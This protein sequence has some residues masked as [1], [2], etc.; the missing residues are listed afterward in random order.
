MKRPFVLWNNPVAC[1]QKTHKVFITFQDPAVNFYDIASASF[2]AAEL[3]L[4][5]LIIR[6]SALIN[7]TYSQMDLDIKELSSYI[8]FKK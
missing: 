1:P 2:V 8:V 6:I 3:C 5:V 7:E 4:S